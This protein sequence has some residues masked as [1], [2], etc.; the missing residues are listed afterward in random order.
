MG[1]DDATGVRGEEAPL[2]DEGC[3]SRGRFQNLP[4]SIPWQ[5]REG[6]LA[7]SKCGG[8]NVCVTHIEPVMA[9]RDVQE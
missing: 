9:H 5:Q 1:V 6:M 7:C 2:E 4:G 3:W 8:S